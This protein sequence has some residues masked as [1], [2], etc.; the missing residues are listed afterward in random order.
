MRRYL[1][2]SR[3]S[4]RRSRMHTRSLRSFLKRYVQV[5]LLPARVVSRRITAPDSE[6]FWG[7]NRTS[8]VTTRLPSS[9][10]RQRCRTPARTS[11]ASQIRRR[12][13]L[14]GR[15]RGSQDLSM[16]QQADLQKSFVIS[17][18]TFSMVL[19]G[20]GG[21]G[22][23]YAVSCVSIPFLSQNAICSPDMQRH[24]HVRRPAP[25]HPYRN[26]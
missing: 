6:M 20:W 22:G 25:P 8:E 16:L 10:S 24:V 7:R 3:N 12:W 23:L 15:S 21:A 14:L 1:W 13:A 11:S 18:M 26:L 2:G 19:M 17:T 5:A 9:T 4:P